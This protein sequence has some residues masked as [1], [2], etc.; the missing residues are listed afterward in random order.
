M[1]RISLLAVLTVLN[2][3]PLLASKSPPASSVSIYDGHVTLKLPDNWV[4]INQGHL[5]EL[6]MW[7]ADATAGRIVEIYQHGFSPI[8]GGA[9]PWLPHML[10]Q[11]RES[12]RISY[13]Q[14]LHLQPLEEYQNETR[15]TFPG[16]LPP[17]IVGVAVER[18]TFNPKTF[19]LRLEHVLDLRPRGRVRVL[20]AAFLTERGLLAIRYVDRERRMDEGRKRF[21]RIVRSVKI[22]PEIAYRPRLI[23]RWPGLPYFISAAVVA[24]A[25]LAF[26]IYRRKKP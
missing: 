16:G 14:F 18:V 25:L 4:E 24:A 8:G 9:E 19:C 22:A 15:R 13:G 10:V 7:A 20:T 11:V 21:N 23:D 26:L 3:A 6:T 2:T 5:E 17:A 1:W 12:G